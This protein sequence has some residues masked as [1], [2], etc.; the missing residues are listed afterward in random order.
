MPRQ[1]RL[2][3]PGTLHHV[4]VR[5]LEGGLIA[6]DDQDRSEF[7]TRLSDAA[8]ATSTTI[9]AWALLPNHIHLLVRSGSAGLPTFMRRLLT[10]YAVVFNR[11]HRRSGHLFQNRYKSI[12]CDEDAYFQE[13]VRYIHLNPLRAGQVPDLHALDTYPWAG[14]AGILGRA[15]QSFLHRREVLAGFGASERSARRAYH[16]FVAEGI[17][18][19]RR[20][21]LV[22]GGLVRSLGGWSEVR[23]VRRRGEMQM[24]DPRILGSG[25]FVERMLRA[26][27]LQSGRTPPL[28]DRVAAAEVRIR[29]RCA[30]SNVTVEELKGGGRRRGLSALRD[31]LA[32]NLVREHGLPCADVA[33]LLGISTSGIAKV[34]G[35][36][37][38]K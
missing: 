15:E 29:A 31:Q 11:R 6:K 2:D 13:L 18:L 4:I 37:V 1:P 14:H 16:R 38:T 20:P 36:L 27:E 3:A 24:A 22:G 12:V 7:V 33:R 17:P 21:H 19:G 34:L 32:V 8:R 5:G 9:Y 28:A 26:P 10:G 35:R 25:D 30:E 23:A